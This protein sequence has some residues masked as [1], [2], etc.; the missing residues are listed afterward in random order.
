M[1]QRLIDK[2][3]ILAYVYHDEGNRSFKNSPKFPSLLSVPAARSA[4]TR[5]SNELMEAN[6]FCFGENCKGVGEAPGEDL[7]VQILA[8]VEG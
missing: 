2:Y 8:D 4:L 1:L 6:L 3:S 7:G 5:N